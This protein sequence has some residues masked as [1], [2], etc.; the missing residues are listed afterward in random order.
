MSYIYTYT[1]KKVYP[2]NMKAEDID[3]RDVA[4]HLSNQC[5][6][7]GAVKHFYSVAEHSVHVSHFVPKEDA[8][9]GLLHDATE[10]YMND[11][12]RPVKDQCPQYVKMEEAILPAIANHFNLVAMIPESVHRVDKEMLIHEMR[13][14]MTGPPINRY[15]EGIT[16]TFW[17]NLREPWTPEIA[18]QAFLR[19]YVQ[20]RGYLENEE[21]L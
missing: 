15:I 13:D 21:S 3:I 4:H 10:A 17:I 9:W 11:I 19:K 14:L 1:G 16:R 8:M 20:L 2:G 18:E 5:R 7:A 6:Y 12:P